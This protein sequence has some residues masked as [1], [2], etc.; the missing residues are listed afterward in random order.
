MIGQLNFSGMDK[1]ETAIK[2][3]QTFAP[4][5]GYY[6]AFS[7]GK[8][9]VV[10]KALADMAGVKYD[11]HY[12]VTSV[13]PPEL[14]YFIREH[15]PDVARDRPLDKNGKQVTMWNLIPKKQM[16]PTR[17]AR[18]CCAA[19]KETGGAGRFVVTGVRASESVARRDHR[20]GLEMGNGKHRGG[21]DPDNPSQSLI[22][23]C[24]N[25]S[26]KILNPIIDWT[27][28]DVWEFIRRFDIPYCSLYDEGFKR[29]GCVGCS[30]SSHRDDEFARY[31]KIKVAYLRAFDRMIASRTKKGL[32]SDEWETP[33]KV[34]KW[35][36]RK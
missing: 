5:D 34:M 14:I 8:D 2:R 18:Y 29:I 27:T 21:F 20:S 7:G 31:P 23:Q 6:L 19:L 28:G 25:H 13:D 1:V 11:A 24:A 9:S 12:R 32:R 10:I 16:P 4:A 22:H 33:E 35:W 30:M 17:L 3:F 26:K 36:L 15:H